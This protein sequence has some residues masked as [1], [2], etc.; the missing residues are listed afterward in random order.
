M[1]IIDIISIIIILWCTHMNAAT[2]HPVYVWIIYKYVLNLFRANDGA[3]MYLFYIP[4]YP[5]I[6]GVDRN[7]NR[8]S[9]IP[10]VDARAALPRFIFDTNPKK[11][12][13]IH[14]PITVRLLFSVHSLQTLSL[15][16]SLSLSLSIALRIP[17]NTLGD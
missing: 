9:H 8:D 2:A 6:Y 3:R 12:N 16:F 14:N 15:W 11:A 1:V 17:N 4:W 5:W 13:F 7:A 10:A